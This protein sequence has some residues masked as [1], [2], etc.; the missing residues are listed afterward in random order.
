MEQ[1]DGYGSGRTRS[2]PDRPQIEEAARAW[3]IETDYWD[4]WGKQHHA[5]PELETAILQIAGRRPEFQSFA[6]AGDRAPAP[7][8]SGARLSLRPSFSPPETPHEVPRFAA[9]RARRFCRN[10]PHSDWKTGA[11]RLN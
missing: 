11:A 5:S 9:G 4:I 8:A 7:S 1:Q 3:G 6:A 2:I 10:S